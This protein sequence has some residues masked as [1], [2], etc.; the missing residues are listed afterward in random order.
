M[1]SKRER[2]VM[3]IGSTCAIL[4]LGRGGEGVVVAGP[5]IHDAANRCFS[6]D[7][8]FYCTSSCFP[9]HGSL[10]G[11]EEKTNLGLREKIAFVDWARVKE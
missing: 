11:L 1:V 4:A 3:R 6:G 7:S 10:C 2:G 8:Q 5:L 9:C